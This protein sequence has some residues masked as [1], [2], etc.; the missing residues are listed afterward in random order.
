[1]VKYTSFSALEEGRLR[2]AVLHDN[3]KRRLQNL[4]KRI[5]NEIHLS[6]E[7]LENSKQDIV[8]LRSEIQ[9]KKELII[10]HEEN[11][12]KSKLSIVSEQLLLQSVRKKLEDLKYVIR[13]LYREEEDLTEKLN[14]NIKPNLKRTIRDAL[15][16]KRVEIKGKELF[17]SELSRKY[18]RITEQIRLLN[19]DVRH[20]TNEIIEIEQ[21]IQED[22][23]KVRQL[24]KDGS[25]QV[26]SSKELKETLTELKQSQDDTTS[27]L[28]PTHPYG[29]HTRASI[30]SKKWGGP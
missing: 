11:V 22:T 5:E 9:K 15:A 3:R 2:T 29:R 27:W 7:N 1:L 28:F 19:T 18:E 17:E 23:F 14:N 20:Q 26:T 21:K 8:G 16:S 13:K 10:G 30:R 6:D 12:Q 4:A 24:T 25:K